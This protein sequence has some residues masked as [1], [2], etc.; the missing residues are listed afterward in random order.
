MRVIQAVYSLK[1]LEK[2]VVRLRIEQLKNIARNDQWLHN[3][4]DIVKFELDAWMPGGSTNGA[5]QQ[6]PATVTGPTG[7]SRKRKADDAAQD[8]RALMP[9]RPKRTRKDTPLASA[10]V[11]QQ[12]QAT[13]TGL[14]NGPVLTV[15]PVTPVPTVNQAAPVLTVNKNTSTQQQIRPNGPVP[16]VKGATPSIQRR[17]V[18]RS[19]VVEFSGYCLPPAGINDTNMDPLPTEKSPCPHGFIPWRWEAYGDPMLYTPRADPWN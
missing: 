2:N 6:T 10:K 12:G 5:Q 9:P 1:N 14:P 4:Y 16:T 7:G 19:I 11:R 18:A 17:R 8:D 13:Q 3:E 15:N